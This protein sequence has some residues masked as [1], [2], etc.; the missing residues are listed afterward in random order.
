MATKGR[1]ASEIAN[2]KEVRQRFFDVSRAIS[3]ES[4]AGQAEPAGASLIRAFND[5]ALIVRDKARSYASQGKAAK[6]IY[7]G[8]TPAIFAFLELGRSDKNKKNAGPL[9]G[10]RTGK[11]QHDTTLWKT[12]GRGTRRRKD[13]TVAVNGLSMSLGAMFERGTRQKGKR[14]IKPIRFFRSA[15]FSSKSLIISKLT[16]AYKHAIEVINR[17]K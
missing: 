16:D 10:V 12:W 6:R 17:L 13:N 4:P 14:A 9:L 8:Q 7:T 1:W 3:K 15:T 11:Y 5:T 2:L